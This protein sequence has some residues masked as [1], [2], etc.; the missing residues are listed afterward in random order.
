M[1]TQDL[2]GLLAAARLCP[3]PEGHKQL[4][5]WGGQGRGL[6][7]GGQLHG[8]FSPS[9]PSGDVSER[10]IPRGHGQ[11]SRRP[12]NSVPLHLGQ[13]GPCPL[14]GFLIPE[15]APRHHSPSPGGEVFQAP[16]TLSRMSS[17]RAER[18]E[19]DLLISS[20]SVT[21]DWPR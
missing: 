5:L 12:W 17:R 7:N 15:S 21:L 19:A 9:A 2:P 6:G 4:S 8:A 11:G 20:G 1:K 10:W 14:A 3:D 16:Q 18:L 13:G